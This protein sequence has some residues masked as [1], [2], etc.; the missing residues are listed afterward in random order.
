M[1]LCF[2][3]EI[4]EDTNREMQLLYQF[5]DDIMLRGLMITVI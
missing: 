5:L 4:R 1:A 2:E 3:T